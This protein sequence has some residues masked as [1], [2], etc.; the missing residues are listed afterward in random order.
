MNIKG[1]DEYLSMSLS[2]KHIPMNELVQYCIVLCARNIMIIPASITTRAV[3]A[4]G[5]GGGGGGGE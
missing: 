3:C 2:T 1:L 5:G 4:Y